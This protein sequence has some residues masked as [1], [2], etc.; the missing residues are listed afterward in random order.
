LT[1]EPEIPPAAPPEPPERHG[2]VVGGLARDQVPVWAPFAALLA[3]LLIVSLVAAAVYGVIQASD[4]S[5][6]STDDLPDAATLA[7]TVFQD[8]VFVFGA[9]V[10][11]KLALGSVSRVRLGL[12]R[13]RDWGTALKWGGG[14][15]ALFW[16]VAI[17]LALI[18]SDPKDQQLVTDLKAEN[19]T[20]V[21][22]GWA[23]LICVLAPVVEEIFFRGF[24]FG[25]FSRRMGV[26]WAALL[27]GLVFGLGHAPAAPIQ[28]IALGAFGVGLCL[29]FWRT[30]SI[31]PCMAL[32]ALNNSITFGATKD[33]DGGLFAAVV[34]LSVGT[35]VAGA[36][37]ISARSAETE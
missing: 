34:V 7:L 16:G 35:V 9:F 15:Y 11:V 20:L 3:V 25:V 12:V 33:L 5:V 22:V 4:P 6:K 1:T 8:L 28:L 19:S 31:I 30:Q 37:A 36:T 29:L 13:V 14:A 27:D 2:R 18:F 24:M 26:V 32:H 17:V 10:A 23:I 21:L